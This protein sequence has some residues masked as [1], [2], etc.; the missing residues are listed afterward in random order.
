MEEAVPF[1]RP[2]LLHP[3]PPYSN[4]RYTFFC[5]PKISTTPSQKAHCG[6]P[7]LLSKVLALS[8]RSSVSLREPP[9]KSPSLSI[10]PSSSFREKMLFLDS[11]GVDLFALAEDHPPIISAS[12]ADL[13]ATIDFLFSLGFSSVDL[14]RMCGMCPEILTAGGPSAFEPVVAFLLQEAGVQIG[15][16]RHVIHRR[17]RLLVSDVAGRLRPTLYFL[18]MLGITETAHHAYLLSCSVEEKLIPRLEFLQ[19]IGFPSR[20]ARSMARRFPRIFCYGIKENLEPKFKFFSGEMGRE[21][22]ELKGFPQ[23]FSFSLEKK[24]RPRHLLCKEHGIF[25][26]L[27]AL[28]RPSDEEFM[29]R[30]EVLKIPLTKFDAPL[31]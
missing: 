18:R 17:P 8:P 26:A 24:I 21:L 4:A 27:P 16:L 28:L 10:E 23:Y 5:L 31:W 2:C 11:A 14:R 1:W 3:P 15:D 29:L 13:R 22:R 6:S 12:L 7:I 19:S 9:G 25:F 20:D 30:L